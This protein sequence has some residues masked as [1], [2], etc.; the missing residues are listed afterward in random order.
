[1]TVRSC[2]TYQIRMRDPFILTLPA[3][4]G[5]LLFGTTDR[6]PWTGPGGGFDCYRSTDLAYWDGPFPA[7]RP[8]FDFWGTTQFWAPEVYAIDDRFVMLATFSDGRHRG[9][10][11]L[12]ADT[13]TGPFQPIGAGPLTPDGWDCLD[14]TLFREDESLW[15]VYCHEWTQI[16]DGR[17]VA[18][19]IDNTFT[20]TM[21]EPLTLFTASE[22]PWASPIPMTPDARTDQGPSKGYVT[23]GPWLHRCPGGELVMLWS[24]SAKFGYA[25]G[26]ARSLTGSIRGP[27]V[28][29]PQPLWSDDGGHPMIFTDIQGKLTMALH[30]PNNAPDERPVFIT[31]DDA[32]GTITADHGHE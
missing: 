17:I 12:I 26:V 7:F 32:N 2:P 25:T 3:G 29:Q 22:A 10:Q 16:G 28:Q 18:Q 6:D 11:A 5:Y 20:S 13:P 1:M 30:Q 23:D 4:D 9:T 21:G 19:Q 24:S 14:G 15:L 27:W 8:P 31:I